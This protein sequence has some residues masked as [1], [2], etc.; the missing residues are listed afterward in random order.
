MGNATGVLRYD[1]PLVRKQ[2][3]TEGL[4]KQASKSFWAPYIGTSADSI[5][6]QE[7]DISKGQGLLELS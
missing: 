3:M 1:S 2:W 7:N 5:V 4:V 6:Y